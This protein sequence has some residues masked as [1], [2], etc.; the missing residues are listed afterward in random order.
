MLVDGYR[1][2]YYSMYPELCHEFVVIDHV[3]LIT[4]IAGTIP[5]L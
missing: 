1:G 5:E 4:C 3:S 2:L